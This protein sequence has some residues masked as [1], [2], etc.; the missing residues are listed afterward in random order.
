MGNPTE[1]ARPST[2]FTLPLV[3]QGKLADSFYA[4][5]VE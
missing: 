1:P 4:K 5:P 3:S 2:E